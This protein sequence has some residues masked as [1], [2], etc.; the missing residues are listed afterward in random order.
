[1]HICLTGVPIGAHICE[2]L[3]QKECFG[4]PLEQEPKPWLFG[5]YRIQVCPKKI[6][7]MD[8]PYTPILGMGFLDHQSY[9]IRRGLDFLGP[10]NGDVI[11]H[12]I[13]IPS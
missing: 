4:K 7:E 11:S 12:E 8:C 13:W 5:F 3:G 10:V 9:S 1:M 2:T 6:E